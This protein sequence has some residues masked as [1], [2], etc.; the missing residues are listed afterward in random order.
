M[1]KTHTIFLLMAEMPCKKDLSV[2]GTRFSKAGGIGES[3]R[4]LKNPLCR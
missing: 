3:L 4:V 1:P 2:Y